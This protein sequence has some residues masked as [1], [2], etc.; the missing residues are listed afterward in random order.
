MYQVTKDRRALVFAT[1]QFDWVLGKNSEGLCMFEGKG[2]RN[3]PDTITVT[4]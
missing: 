4:T 2:E 1:D 3:P